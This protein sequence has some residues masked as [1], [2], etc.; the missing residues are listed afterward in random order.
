MNHS[1]KYIIGATHWL[2]RCAATSGSCRCKIV[3]KRITRRRRKKKKKKKKKEKKK[4]KKKKI[5]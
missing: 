2:A 4:E 1:V 5:N 3:R